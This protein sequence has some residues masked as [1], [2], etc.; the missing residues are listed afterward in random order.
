M[1]LECGCPSSYPEWND[2][3]VDLGGHCIHRISIPTFLHM[4]IG[5]ELHL[6]RQQA[7]IERL[8][9][10]ELWPGL[11]LTRTGMLRGSITRLIEDVGS[12]SRHVTHLPHPY[13][14]RAHL[15]CGNLGTAHKAVREMQGW[16]LDNG[17]MPGELL[18]CHL[19]CPRCADRRGG[20]KIL[21]LRH[22]RHSRMLGKRKKTDPAATR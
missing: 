21:L 13:L 2:E 3:D 22:W 11:A 15:H 12:L 9:L 4:P 19:T 10:R 17:R 6:Q 14:V 16:L 18:L 5:Y 20:E 7:N 1:I 8:G